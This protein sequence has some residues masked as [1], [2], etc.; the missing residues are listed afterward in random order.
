MIDGEEGIADT[1]QDVRGL[2]PGRL[3]AGQHALAFLSFLTHGD[4][5]RHLCEAAKVS[6]LVPQ[7]RDEDVGP[8]G[9]AVLAYP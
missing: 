9:G 8:E 7:G 1:L 5:P 6:L 4:V 2:L 3:L